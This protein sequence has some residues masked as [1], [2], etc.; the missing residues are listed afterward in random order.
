[1]RGTALLFIAIVM[2]LIMAGGVAL[3]ASRTQVISLRCDAPG[4]D[5]KNLNGEYAVVQNI[6]KK[7]VLLAG[8]RIH[9]AGKNHIYTFPAGYKLLPKL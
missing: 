7:G 1:M 6:S 4:D 9:D 3:A 2:V 5:N 8:W